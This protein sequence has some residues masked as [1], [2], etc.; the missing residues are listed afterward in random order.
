[1][2]VNVVYVHLETV[3]N[4]ILSYGISLQDFAGALQRVPHHLLLLTPV[5]LD[6]D[7]DPHTGFNVIS[8]APAIAAYFTDPHLTT[9]K[10][11]DFAHELYL[12]Q[13]TP[14]EV[15]QL[16]YLGHAYT[17]LESPFYYKLQNDYV[18]LD[19]PDGTVK[20]YY[21]HLPQFYAVLNRSLKRHLQEKYPD[22]RFLFRRR[23]LIQDIDP[24]IL[25]QLQPLFIDGALF[26]FEDIDS[27]QKEIHIPILSLNSRFKLVNDDW[28]SADQERVAELIYDH[29]I[30]KW[31]L[32]VINEAAF[33]N[34]GLL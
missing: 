10:W 8:G 17:H 13:V 9:H 20:T 6:D 5:D 31:R 32:N 27:R 30:K 22:M 11:I 33:A 19:L 23:S 28:H 26:S 14:N 25:Q 12:D 29:G 2:S 15:A 1:M 21:R 3:S 4:L 7:V 24:V 16:L 18:Y 34:Q